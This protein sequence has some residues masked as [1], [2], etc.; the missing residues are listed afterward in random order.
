M[1]FIVVTEDAVMRNNTLLEKQY[2]TENIRIGYSSIGWIMTKYD[3]I[4][5]VSFSGTF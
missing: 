4:G 5:Y 1:L 2:A 3:I